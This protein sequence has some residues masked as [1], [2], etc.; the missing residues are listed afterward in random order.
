LTDNDRKDLVVEREV[1]P[2]FLLFTPK[3]G[4]QQDRSEQDG[5]W[6]SGVSMGLQT[7]L[8]L[9]D[10]EMF[11]FCGLLIPS[12]IDTGLSFEQNAHKRAQHDGTIFSSISAGQQ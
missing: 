5:S 2:R 4:T 10:P 11:L 6:A 3:P 9:Q 12:L 8:F 1:N 7:L